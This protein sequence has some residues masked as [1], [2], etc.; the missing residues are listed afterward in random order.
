MV[1]ERDKKASPGYLELEFVEFLEFIGRL[2]HTKFIGSELEFGLD[3]ATKIEYVLD[4]LLALIDLTRNEREIEET[5][6][7]TDSS[8]N[9]G[10]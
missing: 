3:L 7:V 5:Y 8:G 9:E 6:E 4:D 2:A 10:Y 1:V